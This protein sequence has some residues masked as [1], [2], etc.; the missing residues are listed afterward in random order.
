MTSLTPAAHTV[1][2]SVLD[3]LLA[4]ESFSTSTTQLHPIDEK[5]SYA[6]GDGASI[7]P[8][9]SGTST[10]STDGE[11]ASIPYAEA[12]SSKDAI[13]HTKEKQKENQGTTQK[14]KPTGTIRQHLRGVWTVYEH[15]PSWSDSIP[16]VS[17][18]R[19]L[20]GF[21]ETVPYVVLL[22]KDLW[23]LGPYLCIIYIASKMVSGML[24]SLR[25]AQSAAFL[26][27][28]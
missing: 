9:P 4:R 22:L 25:L 11:V 18:Y 28:V 24:P 3:Y 10:P 7:T 20:T 21:L 6:L 12:A 2:S 15:I 8:L 1:L 26:R 5:S 27:M 23:T 19:D 16:G 17:I 14:P 13:L